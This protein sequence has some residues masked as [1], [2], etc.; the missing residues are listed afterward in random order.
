VRYATSY[1]HKSP[2]P[3]AIDRSK[4]KLYGDADEAVA[5]IKSGSVVLSSGFGLCGVAGEPAKPAV[6]WGRLIRHRNPH[7]GAAQ[8]R[9]RRPALADLRVE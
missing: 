1:T 6:I 7:H 5:D 9:G 4:S 3:P 2:E 8:A